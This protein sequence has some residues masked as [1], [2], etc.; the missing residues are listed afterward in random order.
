MPG[1]KT[2]DSALSPWAGLRLLAKQLGA[3]GQL[4][5][6]CWPETLVALVTHGQAT[7]QIEAGK[8]RVTAPLYPGSLV[9][10]PAGYSVKSLAWIGSHEQTIVVFSPETLDGF[11]LKGRGTGVVRPAARFGFSDRGIEGIMRTMRLEIESGCPSGAL[12]G[13]SMSLALVARL[14]SDAW[15][16]SPAAASLKAALTSAQQQRVRNYIA[17]NLTQELTLAELAQLIDA[18]PGHFTRLFR[19]TFG[20]PPYHYIIEQRIDEAKRLMATG[21]SSILEIALLLGFSSQSHFTVTFRKLTGTTPRQFLG[22]L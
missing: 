12:F 9:T 15:K 11:E 8:E 17:Q 2:V 22:N 18:S 10:I 19:N 20:V 5:D 13:E 16:K 7:L 14:A 21:Q 3:Q 1:S 4:R 6:H